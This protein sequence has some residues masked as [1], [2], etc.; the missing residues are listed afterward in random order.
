MHAGEIVMPYGGLLDRSMS[1]LFRV[2]CLPLL[3]DALR[4]HHVRSL[5]LCDVNQE[6]CRIP[7]GTTE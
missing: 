4:S 3:W 1:C 2:D 7:P 5:V 6:H